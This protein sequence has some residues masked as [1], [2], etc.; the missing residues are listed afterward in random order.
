MVSITIKFRGKVLV[1]TSGAI[2]FFYQAVDIPGKAPHFA[3]GS[4]LAGGDNA[5]PRKELR[6][7]N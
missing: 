2:L 3:G 5:P 6:R 7:R 4:Y 1:D